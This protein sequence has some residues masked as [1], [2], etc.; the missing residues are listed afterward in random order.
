MIRYIAAI[1]DVTG[2]FIAGLI[3]FIIGSLLLL[4]KPA[5]VK[6]IPGIWRFVIGTGMTFSGMWVAFGGWQ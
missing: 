6:A 2:F 4:G 5:V 1:N 3:I